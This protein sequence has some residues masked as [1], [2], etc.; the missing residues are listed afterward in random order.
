MSV[1]AVV[2]CDLR[3]NA[4]GLP[5]RALEAV[6]GR[7]VLA[8]TL[9]RLA[10]CERIDAVAVV[11]PAVQH[12]AIREATAGFD[13]HLLDLTGDDLPCR[14]LQRRARTWALAG[15]R[16]GLLGATVFD[17]FGHPALARAAETLQA[18]T[19]VPVSPEWP[20]IDPTLLAAL[21]D[22]HRAQSGP[23]GFTFSQA[24]PGLLPPAYHRDRLA[25]WIG[26]GIVPGDVL[27]FRLDAPRIDLVLEACCFQVPAAARRCEHRLAAD[28]ARGAALVRAIL[29][30]LGS[31]PDAEA[32]CRFVAEHPETWPGSR[33]RE[34]DLELTTRRPVED[35]L[36]P[37]PPIAEAESRKADAVRLV[38][39]AA[40]GDD[41]AL[42][43]GGRGDP[44]LHPDLPAVLH[45]AREAGVFGLH[46]VTYG[47]NL[48]ADLAQTM[49]E[50]GVDAVT[51]LLDA[52]TPAAY[53]RSK[54]GASSSAVLDGLQR[55][56]EARRSADADW[57][58][59][60]AEFIKTAETL[61]EMEAFCDTWLRRG[62]WPVIRGPSDR[63]GLVDDL[64]VISMAPPR[65]TPCRR[66]FRGL[67]VHATGRAPA[68]EEDVLCRQ[69]LGEI[70]RDGL[71]GIWHGRPLADLRRAHLDQRLESCPACRDC[72]EWHRP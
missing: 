67:T 24:P 44:L 36:R 6:A 19:V 14:R 54:G 35:A 39:E 42:T 53:A 62:A 49:V 56:S 13:I 43:L 18:D 69:C 52:D 11:A 29:D 7:P 4:L 27:R 57:P 21:I 48:T 40:A 38:R 61:P 59:V 12:D 46:L 64:S 16:G 63:A 31:T 45:A 28:T 15:W 71:E 30:A 58:I 32:V 1:A 10:R 34:V 72:R 66:L 65:R 20:L 8:H 26:E 23:F 17:E 9:D 60:V 3:R 55:L 47:R 51:F 33:P 2:E 70:A 5:S 25:R 50:T 68:C 22:H 37:L 41:T